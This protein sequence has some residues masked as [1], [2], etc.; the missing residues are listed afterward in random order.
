MVTEFREKLT[1]KTYWIILKEIPFSFPIN[2]LPIGTFI[3]LYSIQG[4]FLSN[5]S[6]GHF[7]RYQR[8]ENPKTMKG[9][10]DLRFFVFGIFSV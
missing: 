9:G 1:R 2:P 6:R 10:T 3:A 7:R 4:V 8:K 5:R